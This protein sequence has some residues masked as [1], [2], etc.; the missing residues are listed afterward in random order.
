MDQTG[1]PTFTTMEPVENGF[2]NLA[3]GNLHIEI[4]L[5]A[6]PERGGSKLAPSLIYDSRMW[7]LVPNQPLP[8]G[9]SGT[10]WL[11]GSLTGKG[12]WR[13]VN[14]RD[15]GSVSNTWTHSTY[16]CGFNPETVQDHGPFFYNMGDGT[17]REF[18]IFTHED[19]GTCGYNDTPTASGYA[20]DGSGHLL[21][22]TNYTNGTVYAP[23][24]C[25]PN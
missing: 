25:C 5:T 14:V 15:A 7:S 17:Q 12:G 4:P 21:K 16:T 19:H 10:V 20:L 13:F 23:D 6:V 11:P 22:V 18:D 8:G 2:I 24:H 1:I 9:G 3:N